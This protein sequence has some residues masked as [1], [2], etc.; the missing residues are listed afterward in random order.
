VAILV[1]LA[2]TAAGHLIAFGCA[3]GIG[4]ELLGLPR[5]TNNL[6][7]AAGEGIFSTI[8]IVGTLIVARTCSK[9]LLVSVGYGALITFVVA[10]PSLGVLFDTEVLLLGVSYTNVALLVS[11]SLALFHRQE[12]AALIATKWG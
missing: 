4:N 1:G 2:A 5:E 3:E 8:A 7:Y 6:I 12:F 10:L 9:A 11:M